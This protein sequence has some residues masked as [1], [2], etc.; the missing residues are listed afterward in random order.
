M[1]QKSWTEKMIG[2]GCNHK[3]TRGI[4]ALVSLASPWLWASEG[5]TLAPDRPGISSGTHTVAPGTLY[6]ES[7]FQ[8]SVNR[9]GLDVANYQLPQLVFRT[10]VTDRLEFDLLWAGWNRDALQ[11][12][13]QQNSA[14]DVSIGGK[15]RLR[16]S[17]RSNLTLFG[18]LSAP[19]GTAPSTSDSWDPL[20]GFL[21]DYAL[22]D[23]TQL[24]VNLLAAGYEDG[25]DDV[26]E[27]QIMVGL[28]FSHS[29][30]LSSFIEYFAAF[31]DENRVEE[32]SV[33]DGGFT[34]YPSP[35]IQFDLSVGMGLND[36]SSHFVS[37][38]VS[39]R[40]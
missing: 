15:Y 39:Y 6:I 33:I 22:S 4:A 17:E 38:G 40:Y 12:A 34:Y 27:S 30:K 26:V 2:S 20:L 25:N 19:V 37:F 14:A 31:P 28:G 9:S 11:G 35:D 36:A 24:F 8:Y 3:L 1:T 7:G 13:P 21:Y 29:P 32:A 18:L 5:G 10:G 23:D 16:Q